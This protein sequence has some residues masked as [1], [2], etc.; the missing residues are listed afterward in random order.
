MANE[1]IDELRS[2]K[3]QLDEKNA[4]LEKDKSALNQELS[5]EKGCTSQAQKKYKEKQARIEELEDFLEVERKQKTQV[6]KQRDEL[7]EELADLEAKLEEAGGVTQE[8][9]FIVISH[10]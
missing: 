3:L 5:E 8:Q 1:T 4:K 10:F 2:E 7:R 9:S 6:T